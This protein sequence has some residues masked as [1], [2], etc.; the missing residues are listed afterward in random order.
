MNQQD[1]INRVTELLSWWGMKIKANNALSF[2]DIN[3]IAEGLAA[4]LLNLTYNYRL[5][6]LELHT[7]NHA[8]ID[9]GGDRSDIAFQVTATVTTQKIKDNSTTFFK[10]FAGKYSGGIR[11]L[12]LSPDYREIE[13]L[14]KSKAL[15][16]IHTEFLPD[17][18]ILSLADLTRDICNLYEEKEDRFMQIKALLEKEI[19]PKIGNHHP[20]SA[21]ATDLHRLL[22]TRSRLH[23]EDLTGPDGR[24]RH[25]DISDIIL[26]RPRAKQ[27]LD[28]P[29]ES[30][31]PL[32]DNTGKRLTLPDLL[33]L[34]WRR[35]CK[36]AMVKGDG[37]MGK[38]VSLVRL[39][40]RLTDAYDAQ[41]PVPLFIQLNEINTVPQDRRRE[42][43]LEAIAG[44]YLDH[45][46][47]DKE[48]IRRFLKEPGA[49]ECPA[50]VLLLDGFNEVT[51]D[52]KPLVLELRQI[53]EQWRGVQLL[54]TGR[55]DMRGIYGWD[56]LQLLELRGLDAAHINRYLEAQNRVMPTGPL[57]ELLGNP[58]MLTIYAATCEV[59]E[60]TRGDFKENV[61]TGANCCGILWKPSR[62]CCGSGAIMMR[63]SGGSTVS[64]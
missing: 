27:W 17:R 64:C 46:N 15:E 20:E 6:K 12:L 53:L 7:P 60:N 32:D 2:T 8:A 1:H 57:A 37:G 49:G 39:W 58:M 33:P 19:R 29:V 40:E 25:L 10:K 48:T 56:Q 35:S 47:E 18:H 5:Q 59:R 41:K 52:K 50:V 54:I 55:H 14:K 28:A 16:N 11:F 38:T 31:T 13:R 4:K 63:R 61:T 3:H 21:Q 62:R 34:L 26:Q 44:N 23:Y 51:V 45:P 43:I 30:D 9:L 42:S 36:H 22:F 24:F